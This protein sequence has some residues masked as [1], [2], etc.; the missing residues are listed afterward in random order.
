M[1]RVLDS[2]RRV[3]VQAQAGDIV[4]SLFLENYGHQ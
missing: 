3:R 4:L 2:Y 1:V